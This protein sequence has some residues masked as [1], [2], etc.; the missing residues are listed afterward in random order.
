MGEKIEMWDMNVFHYKN[1][2]IKINLEKKSNKLILKSNQKTN[3]QFNDQEMD[4]Y[5]F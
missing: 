4:D 3:D 5:E 1:P 2:H